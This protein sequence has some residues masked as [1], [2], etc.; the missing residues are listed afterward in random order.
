MKVVKA[1][2]RLRHADVIVVSLGKSGRTWLRVM[3]N[4]YLS[5]HYGT[6]FS[7]DD[8]HQ[9]NPAIPSIIYQHHLW[10]NFAKAPAWL[11]RVLERFPLLPRDVFHKKKV[12]LLTRDPRDTI[13]SNYFQITKRARADKRID[14]I[15]I[16]DFIRHGTWGIE[17]RVRVMNLFLDKLR[18]HPR[19]LVVTY[20]TMKADAEE[21]LRRLLRFIDIDPNAAQVTEAVAFADFGNMRRMEESNELQKGLLRP[22]DPADPDSFKVRKGKVGGYVEYLNATDIAYVERHVA[23]LSPEYGYRKPASALAG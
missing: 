23:T 3:L 7:T 9:Q 14:D 12:V 13:V 4:K 22:G 15:S 8:L 2:T 20:E 6:P 21:Q 16:S 18:G 10:M 17:A 11:N 1:S 5:L 19:S